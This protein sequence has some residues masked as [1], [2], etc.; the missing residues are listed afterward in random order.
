MQVL[1]QLIWGGSSQSA[2][3]TGLQVLLGW[4]LLPPKLYT[5]V[6]SSSNR[7]LPRL[8]SLPSHTSLCL[9]VHVQ[10]QTCACGGQK[11]N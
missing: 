9:C 1:I 8:E 11:T 6:T 7:Q 4:C 10:V 2:L 5:L 3:L